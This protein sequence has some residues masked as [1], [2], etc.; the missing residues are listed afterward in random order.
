MHDMKTQQ[1]F[2]LFLKRV[3]TLLEKTWDLTI[4][5]KKPG[6]L[7]KKPRNFNNFNMLSSKILI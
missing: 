2:L 3:A 6:I 5:A 4:Q 7:N 1:G